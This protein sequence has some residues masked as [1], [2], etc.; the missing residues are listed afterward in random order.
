METTSIAANLS[1]HHKSRT[2]S[3]S[4]TDTGQKACRAGRTHIH[5]HTSS[6]THTHTYKEPGT[7]INV[8]IHSELI[9]VWGNKSISSAAQFI[10]DAGRR[11]L[12]LR[13]LLQKALKISLEEITTAHHRL[14][15]GLWY[16]SFPHTINH[17]KFSYKSLS[18][19]FFT[20]FTCVASQNFLNLSTDCKSR[21]A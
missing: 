7:Q 10:A 12:Q 4:Q 20:H 2:L 8:G 5:P 13:P 17:S 3:L 1:Q 19:D 18:L 21:H 15:R 11:G 16:L 14:K 6:Y 9:F